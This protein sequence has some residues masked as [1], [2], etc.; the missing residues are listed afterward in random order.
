MHPAGRSID[1]ANP[2][3]AHAPHITIF[4]QSGACCSHGDKND[5]V[6]QTSLWSPGFRNKTLLSCQ[7]ALINPG[8]PL[9]W[10]IVTFWYSWS[11]PDASEHLPELEPH[12]PPVSYLL[13]NRVT[14]IWFSPIS[15]VRSYGSFHLES[16][17]YLMMDRGWWFCFL[18]YGA[19]LFYYDDKV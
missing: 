4:T 19:E 7:R 11:S 18:T 15:S 3:N 10:P 14:L 13:V 5:N 1:T 6:L 12:D 17:A 9:W 16:P 2:H 8:R